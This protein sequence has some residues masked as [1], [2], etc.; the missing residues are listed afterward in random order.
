[1]AAYHVTDSQLT[2]I[3]NA[4]RQKGGTHQPLQFPNGFVGAIRALT[5]GAGGGIDTSDANAAAADI[6]LGKTAYVNG[7]KLT[8]TFDGFQMYKGTLSFST[9]VAQIT[10][11]NL[12]FTPVGMVLYHTRPGNA[13]Y[14]VSGENT[15][16]FSVCTVENTGTRTLSWNSNLNGS[17]KNG[18]TNVYLFAGDNALQ[19]YVS[20]VMKGPY[21]YTLWGR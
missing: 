10:M 8:G 12:P 3:A 20:G 7:E 19:F 18:T 1:M 4:L 6:L 21:A 14:Y 11:E 2:T 16:L 13:T 9:P 17:A 15:L 5:A